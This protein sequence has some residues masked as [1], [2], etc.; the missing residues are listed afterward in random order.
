MTCR[1]S[2]DAI[3]RAVNH[4]RSNAF[5]PYSLTEWVNRFGKVYSAHF[6]REFCLCKDGM[7]R[8]RRLSTFG[9]WVDSFN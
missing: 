4:Y 5:E 3:K 6:V 2:I 1:D 8:V 7:V 9:K